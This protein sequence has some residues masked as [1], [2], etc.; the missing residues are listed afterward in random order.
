M[1]RD[2]HVFP[3][4]LLRT[5][6]IEAVHD[7]DHPEHEIRVP[8]EPGPLESFEEFVMRLIGGCVIDARG[9]DE[10]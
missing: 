10:R 8:L 7:P 3:S 4:K 9:R 5:V 2:R 6:G 1:T